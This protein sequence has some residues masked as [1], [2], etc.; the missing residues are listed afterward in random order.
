MQFLRGIPLK[1]WNN[2]TSPIHH[3]Q[4]KCAEENLYE[5]MMARGGSMLE[6]A[7]WTLTV[8]WFSELYISKLPFNKTHYSDIS[9]N[10][11]TCSVISSDRKNN[12]DTYIP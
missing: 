2:C 9:A 10:L 6:N 1:F 5:M 4:T 12:Y 3:L 11:Y 7:N 8:V